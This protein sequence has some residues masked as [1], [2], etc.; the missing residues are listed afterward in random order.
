MRIAIWG[1]CV[2]RDPL[3]IRPH[4]FDPIVYCARTSWVAQ[5]A[6]R[7]SFDPDIGPD[8]AGKFGER[9]VR[10]DFGRLVVERL[11][12]QPPDLVVFDLIDERFDLV[13]TGGGAWVTAS[14]YFS[15]ISS[16]AALAGAP[17]DSLLFGSRL[18]RF[19]AAVDVMVPLLTKALPGALFV[20]HGAFFT[21][22][23]TD[24]S[25]QFYPNAARDAVLIND[26]LAALG[27][28]IQ[29]AFGDR[30]L[31]YLPDPAVQQADAAHKWGLAMYHYPPAYCA[32][33]LD[34]LEAVAAG[35]SHPH[36][37]GPGTPL[38][39]PRHVVEAADR[40]AELARSGRPLR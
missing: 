37:H 1:S 21:P 17:R 40:A 25:V 33:L 11:S 16:S 32:D 36:I 24:P 13:D 26:V 38:L 14:D 10:D 7:P 30:L 18:E 34:A 12:A 28:E 4:A 8:L 2:T 15:S 6:P 5:A 19:A 27:R 35:G 31:T 22:I 20:L 29:R 39:P 9:M 23:P 3:E